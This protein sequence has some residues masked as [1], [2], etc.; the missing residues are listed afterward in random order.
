MDYRHPQRLHLLIKR[1]RFLLNT[2]ERPIKV[3]AGRTRMPQHAY[4]P[5]FDRAAIQIFNNVNDFYHVAN[6]PS[7]MPADWIIPKIFATSTILAL[8]IPDEG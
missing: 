1:T 5:I 7:L 3:Y 8:V 4:E 2:I 6:T